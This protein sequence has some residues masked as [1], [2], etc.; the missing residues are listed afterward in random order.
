[1][2]YGKIDRC[3]FKSFEQCT[4]ASMSNVINLLSLRENLYRPFTFLYKTGHFADFLFV[5]GDNFCSLSTKVK[6]LGSYLLAFC[7]LP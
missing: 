4:L 6:L 1:M 2:I 5:T 3:S 7:L